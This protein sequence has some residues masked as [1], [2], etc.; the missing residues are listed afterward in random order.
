MQLANVASLHPAVR[1][2]S[3]PNTAMGVGEAAG[4]QPYKVKLSLE[5]RDAAALR[6][7]A[8]AVRGALETFTL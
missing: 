2:G 6:K 8:D 3:Y 5:S 4:G 7:A 1:I